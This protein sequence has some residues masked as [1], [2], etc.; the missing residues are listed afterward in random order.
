MHNLSIVMFLALCIACLF[1]FNNSLA[2]EDKTM[3]PLPGADT[4]GAISFE[5]TLSQRR[6]I[7]NFKNTPLS[8]KQMAQLLWAGQGVTS[9]YGFRTAPS[10][11]ALYPLEIYVVA[12]QVDGLAPG[13]Y[14]YIPAH[15]ALKR[16]ASGDARTDF[17]QAGL[18][19]TPILQAPVTVLISGVF[20]RITGKYGK[21]GVQYT[22]IEAG[23]AGQNILLQAVS[24]GL[25]ALPI[26]AFDEEKVSR[27]LNFSPEET[28]L[29]LIPVGAF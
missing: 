25:G 7:R 20:K 15:H 13:I 28:P 26:G 19:Q 24:L 23:H 6:S 12:G 11:G 29:Y 16:I 14:Q 1:D 5:K 18:G 27:L 10:A 2:M 17:C 9:A 21:R 3:I 22:L 4:H 8:L